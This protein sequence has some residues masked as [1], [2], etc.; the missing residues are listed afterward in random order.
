MVFP[1]SITRGDTLGYISQQYHTTVADLVAINHI[2]HANYIY[3]GEVIYITA[4]TT[5]STSQTTTFHYTVESGNTLWS[6]AQTYGTTVD[7]I[8]S[9]NNITNPNLIYVG[10]VLNIPS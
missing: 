4:Q 3:P 7:A 1:K 8:A 5:S 10:E 6:L 9:L 2:S